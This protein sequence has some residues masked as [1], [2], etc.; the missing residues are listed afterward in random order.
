MGS[1]VIWRVYIWPK[2]I[3]IW[4]VKKNHFVDQQDIGQ[5]YGIHLCSSTEYGYRQR[6]KAAEKLLH[7]GNDPWADGESWVIPIS[8]SFL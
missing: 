6:A 3:Q 5:H 4:L 1:L 2:D 8:S 7:K